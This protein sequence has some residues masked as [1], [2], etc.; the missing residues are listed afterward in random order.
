MQAGIDLISSSFSLNY[1]EDMECDQCR[2]K[3]AQQTNTTFFH[4]A[5][6]SQLTEVQSKS[7]HRVCGLSTLFSISVYFTRTAPHDSAKFE[8]NTHCA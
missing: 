8:C 2:Y 4:L 1:V 5:F 6:P 3:M 7:N